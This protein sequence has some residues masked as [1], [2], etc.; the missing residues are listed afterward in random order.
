M[1][2]RY[3]NSFSSVRLLKTMTRRLLNVDVLLNTVDHTMNL[4]TKVQFGC[5]R[6]QWHHF[7]P[8]VGGTLIF[9]LLLP[10]KTV[11]QIWLKCNK[12]GVYSTPLWEVGDAYPTYLHQWLVHCYLLTITN[13]LLINLGH[14]SPAPGFVILCR[15]IGP[16]TKTFN[17]NSEIMSPGP[18]FV[19]PVYRKFLCYE[20]VWAVWVQFMYGHLWTWCRNAL[21]H[22][23]LC[24]CCSD[25]W[26]PW[27]RKFITGMKVYLQR[28]QVRLVHVKVIRSRSQ[29]QTKCHCTLFELLILKALI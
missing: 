1:H 17:N 9:P 28:C 12:Y 5:I 25:F 3:L 24:V 7:R 20:D 19:V 22:V 16:L 4:S 11:H 27:P 15:H 21:G 29:E 18:I 26:R 13:L 8:K 10:L 14:V 6:H 23:C 2:Y